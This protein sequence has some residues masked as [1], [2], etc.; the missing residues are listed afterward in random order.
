M[1]QRLLI[2]G[3]RS[4]SGKALGDGGLPLNVLDRNFDEKPGIDGKDF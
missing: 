3:A 4:P 1:V 2:H